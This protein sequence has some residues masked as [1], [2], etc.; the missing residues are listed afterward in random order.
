MIVVGA[1]VAGL[2]VAYDLARDGVAVTVVEASDHVGGQLASIRIAGT[3]VDA[4]AEAFATR[5]GVVASVAADLGLSDD[6]VVPCESPA[7][8]IGGHGR[9][10]PLPAASVLGIPVD[11]RAHDVRAAI[12]WAA[13]W[14]ARLDALAPLRAP[15]EYR[16][17]GDLVRRRMGAR[18][19]DRL[20][21][22]VVR[23]VYSTSPDSLTLE[24]ASAG[25]S[26]ALRESGSLGAA[27]ARLRTASPAGSQVAGLRGGVHRL[28][29]SLES[30]ARAAG[31]DFLLG[32]RVVAVERDGVR[33]E[34]G[35]MLAGR[36]VHAA[37]GTAGTASRTREVTVAIA[38]VD[39]A[40]LD[41]APRGTGALIE[42]GA[43]GISARAFT[44]SSAKWQWLADEL[45]PHRHIVRLSYD[46]CPHDAEATVVADLQ[47][48]TGVRIDR[49]V[50]L[51]IRTWTRTLQVDPAPGALDLV[52]EA[53][54]LTGLASIVAG[55]R[56][57]ARRIST[58]V[59]SAH[60]GG[61]EG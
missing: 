13:A 10:H 36:I 43:A 32:T 48:T 18:V 3:L 60:P 2:I 55:A 5:G 54:S 51:E 25:L 33:L 49:L 39:A 22:P 58:D 14:R 26:D 52:G 7:W 19:H 44:H 61:A 30:A 37:A 31:A 8:V 11:P 38:A 23:G 21:A 42:E 29:S 16:S 59:K 46:E 17:L 34:D 24:R 41:S 1:G 35:R 53:A 27:V 40:G 47:A 50:D 6:L 9:A 28:A 45:E 57:T 15:E 56:S 4:A 20:V 12:G